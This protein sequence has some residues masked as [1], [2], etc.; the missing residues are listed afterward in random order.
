MLFNRGILNGGSWRIICRIKQYAYRIF[1]SLTYIRWAPFQ[2]GFCSAKT[3]GDCS[4][5]WV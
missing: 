2:E 4:H 3:E 5:I 1:E